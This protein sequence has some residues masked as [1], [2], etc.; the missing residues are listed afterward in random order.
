MRVQGRKQ[1][2]D[3]IN[4]K[5]QYKPPAI[6]TDAKCLYSLY[7]LVPENIAPPTQKK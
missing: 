1:D 5:K 6:T 3:N 4:Q 7:D 2:V